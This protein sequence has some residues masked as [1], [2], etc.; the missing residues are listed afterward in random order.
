MTT[1]RT[2]L[3][4]ALALLAAAAAR[5]TA[6]GPSP[7]DPNQPQIGIKIT[8]TAQRQIPI[9]ILPFHP[10]ATAD[11]A[12][13]TS[14][15]SIR[16]VITADLIYSGLFNVL[17]P[18]LYAG[19]T[20]TAAHPPFPDFAALGAEGLVRGSIAR[21]DA[22]RVVEGPLDDTKSGALISGKRYRGDPSLARHIAHSV[23]NDITLAYTGRPG[24]ALSRIVFVGKV[25]GAKEIHM[26]HYDGA[27]IRQI[28]KNKTLNVSPS[29]SPDGGR[30]AFVS[31]RQGSPRL[32]IYSGEDGSLKDS[33]PPGSELCVAPDWSPDGRLIAFSSSSE[34]DSDIFILDVAT[35]RS[36]QISFSRG[37][38]TSPDWSPSGREI[39]FTSDRSGTPQVYIMDAEGA[40]VRLL[41]G[42]GEFNDS[43][44]WSPDGSR[45][46]YA[47]MIDGRFDILVQD[48]ATGGVRRLTQNAGNNEN[49]RWSSDGRHIAFSSNRSRSYRIYTMDADGNRQ[50]ELPTPIEATMPDWSR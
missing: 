26:M 20:L 22:Q 43:A 36:R 25:G 28:T 13:R 16:G 3:P 2:F 33:T 34:G 35:G 23:A 15:E 39:A 41:T 24:I 32:Y 44:A 5:T 11:A 42:S 27:E 9:A 37:S 1:R 14:A 7:Q 29:W 47:S 12:A 40:N 45:I 4:A 18:S 49:P 50:E 21:K 17:P 38:D 19:V 31:Y 46:A 48:L 30:L 6:G 8:G 10:D